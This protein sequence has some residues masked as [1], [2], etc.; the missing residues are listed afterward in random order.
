MC[1]RNTVYN[2]ILANLPHDPIGHIGY[3]E[4]LEFWEAMAADENS[5]RNY[6]IAEFASMKQSV[7]KLLTPRESS[8]F[9]EPFPVDIAES[10]TLLQVKVIARLSKILMD[11]HGFKVPKDGGGLG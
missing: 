8:F 4:L 2:G 11:R 7:A 9:Q 6:S 1:L 5:G 10:P 3:F